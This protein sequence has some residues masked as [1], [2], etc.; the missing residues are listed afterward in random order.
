[1]KQTKIKPIKASGSQVKHRKRVGIEATLKYSDEMRRNMFNERRS[2]KREFES[3]R[4][5]T[6][7][8]RK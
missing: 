7:N 3:S 8:R 4:K 5:K 2:L 6:E 1:M